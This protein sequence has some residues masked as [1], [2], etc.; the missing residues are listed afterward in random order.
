MSTVEYVKIPTHDHPRIFYSRLTAKMWCRVAGHWW[1][2]DPN[3]D[4]PEWVPWHPMKRV[5]A[6]KAA[7]PAAVPTDATAPKA[8]KTAKK[9]LKAPRVKKAAAPAAPS[10][11]RMDR[12][13]SEARRDHAPTTAGKPAWPVRRS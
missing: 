4:H 10:M 5:K 13:R 3:T 6:M 9:V 1:S 7:T 11:P 8:T 2:L 12:L